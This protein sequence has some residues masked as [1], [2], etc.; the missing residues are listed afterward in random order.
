MA[1]KALL[2]GINNYQYIGDLSGC[3]NDVANMKSLLEDS[4]GFESENIRELENHQVTYDNIR[5]GFDWLF[6]DAEEGDRLVFH[7]SGHGSYKPSEDDDEPVDELLCL[8]SMDWDDEDSF[9]LDDDLGDLLK[10]KPDGVIMTVVLDCCHSG[11]GTK[12]IAG[13]KGKKKSRSS[14]SNAS[15]DQLMIISDAFNSNMAGMTRAAAGGVDLKLVKPS[16]ARFVQPPV[17]IQKTVDELLSRAGTKI[18]GVGKNARDANVWNHQLLA[19][20]MDK[21]TAADAFINS[22]Y[23]GAFTYNLCKAYR[24]L[25]DVAVRDLM[26]EVSDELQ[27]GGYSQVPQLEGTRQSEKLL[28]GEATTYVSEKEPVIVDGSLPNQSNSSGTGASS[29]NVDAFHQLLRTHEKFLD[30]GQQLLNC[31]N[32]KFTDSFAQSPVSVSSSSRGGE[33]IV[34]VHGISQHRDGYSDEWYNALSPYLSRSIPKSEVLWSDIVNPR[35]VSRS[36]ASEDQELERLLREIEKEVNQRQRQNAELGSSDARSVDRSWFSSGF[37]SDD[38]LRYMTMESVRNEILARFEKEVKPLLESGNTV[39]IVSHSWGTVVAFEGLKRLDNVS[40]PGTV[41]NLF[42]VGSALSI[43]PVRWNLFGRVSN[44][45]KPR[46]VERIY[47][48]DAGG[49][50]VGGS[51]S[52]H[53]EIDSEYIGLDPVGCR[54]IPFTG[55]AMSLSCA[56]SSYFKSDNTLVNRN[57]F[58]RWING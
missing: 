26:N 42:T 40:L 53:F 38:F 20:A 21:Q 34:Y 51:I 27:K 45:R 25:G 43:A 32:A 28:G 39:H 8:Y 10:R 5:D 56:H 31:G 22:K 57:I 11:T 6:E 37:M 55:I 3:L 24:N 49:D 14:K 23:Q 46:H 48:I 7:F 44:G 47:N 12:A 41:R 9:L 13:K 4:F 58:A 17:R 36:S 52:E 35:S 15:Q 19:G 33:H 54:K 18:R 1:D 50:A 29:S 16:F 30:L 2:T